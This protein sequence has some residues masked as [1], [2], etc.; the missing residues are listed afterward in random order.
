MTQR[1]KPTLTSSSSLKGR[2][3]D[4]QK[5]RLLHKNMGRTTVTLIV[6]LWVIPISILVN[7]IVPDSYMDEIF[8]IPQAQQ[9]CKA[10][11]KSW[12]PMITTPPGL[13]CLSLAHVASLFPGMLLLQRI[14]SFSE[15]CS[16]AILRSVNGLGALAVC[17]RQTNIIWVLFVACEGVI[18]MLLVNRQ[19]IG[20]QKLNMS[21]S[22]KDQVT[23]IA[24]KPGIRR[25]KMKSTIND[26]SSAV[27]SGTEAAVSKSHFS[28]F[29][30]LR[31][32]N[33]HLSSTGFK[34]CF[35]SVVVCLER[36]SEDVGAVNQRVSNQ[37][38]P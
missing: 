1:P 28:V 16:T 19:S 11:F 10:N 22:E 15:L 18:D 29:P 31:L 37:I 9:Y 13:Y 3:A 33:V 23:P 30:I 21:I 17:I 2:I 8:H 24:A 26:S 7:R 35:C 5:N 25:R 12:D 6:S 20:F 14:S 36:D 34:N 4:L 27:I 38:P 32:L